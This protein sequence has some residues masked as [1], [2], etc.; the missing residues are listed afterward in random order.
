MAVATQ[1]PTSVAG[2]EAQ[3]RWRLALA[4]ATAVGGSLGIA[5]LVQRF[6]LIPAIALLT[7][8]AIAAIGWWPRVGLCVAFT[9]VLL[10]EA[11]GPDPLMLPGAYF[12]GG[13]AATAGIPGII[14]SP[15]ELLL[16]LTFSMWLSRGIMSRRLEYQG[17]ALGWPLCVFMVLVGFGILRGVLS[18]GDANVALWE[19][20]F[21]FYMAA[22]YVLAANTI[23]TPAHVRQLLG[24]AL[25]A[26]GLFALEGAYRRIVLVPA[27][28]LAVAKEFYFAHE[29]SV[30][31]GIFILLVVAQWVYGGS[32]W[33]K[34]W[35]LA[36]LPVAIFTL[37]VTERRAGQIALMVAFLALAAVIFATRRKAFFLIVVPVLLCGAIYLPLFWRNTGTLGQPARAVRSL[38]EP[39]PRDAASNA[40]R[41]AEKENVR[42][43]IRSN[44][45]LGVGFGQPFYFVVPMADLSWWPFWR[46][47]PH[48]NVLWIWLKTGA[49]GF[50]SFWVLMGLAIARAGN[51]ARRLADP[52]LRNAAILAL[53]TLVSILVFAYVDLAFVS[54][55]VTVL[56]GTVLGTLAVLDR[57]ERAPPPAPPAGAAAKAGVAAEARSNG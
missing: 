2:Q 11:G 38:W 18:G 53:V 19:S 17:G 8:L 42:I 13:L 46:Y 20:R 26:I 43:T 41:F 57:L 3:R 5:W 37:L 48:H 24:L 52:D 9:L 15:L 23:R 30:F 47:E 22:C 28:V 35:G 34:A 49:A 4:V 55:R 12:N 33:Q 44:P 32:R 16:L 14:A 51:L 36:L 54:G 27:G 7:W 29:T 39:D 25:L 31:L 21:I 56:V 40:Y 50:I 6:Q 10:F 45:V 1:T